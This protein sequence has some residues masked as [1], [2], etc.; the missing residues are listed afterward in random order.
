[1]GRNGEEDKASWGDGVGPALEGGFWN[2]VW[3]SF[4]SNWKTVPNMVYIWGG[5]YILITFPFKTF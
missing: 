1:M 5:Q 3:I 4:F 2:S